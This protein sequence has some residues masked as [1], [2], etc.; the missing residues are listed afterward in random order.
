MGMIVGKWHDL[1]TSVGK[2]DII[3][4]YGDSQFPMQLRMFAEAVHGKAPG[5]SSGSAM[6][7][8]LMAMEQGNSEGLHSDTVDM[9]KMF[10]RR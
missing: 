7:G 5:G 8:I 3:E 9:S 2:S 4:H 1:R 10:S 6:R